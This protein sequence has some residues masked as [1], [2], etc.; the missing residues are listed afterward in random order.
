MKSKSHDKDRTAKAGAA[1]PAVGHSPFDSFS[2]S[3]GGDSIT[4][5][6][7]GWTSHDQ[8]DVKE[9]YCPRCLIFHE[10]RAFMERLAQGYGARFSSGSEAAACSRIAA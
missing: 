10:D 1:A 3:A 7:C 2:I 6:L 8:R 9:K 5:Y 4:C